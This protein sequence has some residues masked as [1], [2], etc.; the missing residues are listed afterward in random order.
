M[1]V[2]TL[3]RALFYKGIQMAFL[4]DPTSDGKTHLYCA[5]CGR[6]VAWRY[7]ASSGRLEVIPCNCLQQARKKSKGGQRHV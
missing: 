3:R 5:N 2:S 4:V 1:C 7:L 6:V